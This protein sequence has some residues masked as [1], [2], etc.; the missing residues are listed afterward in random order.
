[1]IMMSSDRCWGKDAGYDFMFYCVM[2]KN[3]E[4]RYYTRIVLMKGKLIFLMLSSYCVQ[5][6]N[7]RNIT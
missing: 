3:D 1:M 5:Y 6:G 4:W 2:W 7:R